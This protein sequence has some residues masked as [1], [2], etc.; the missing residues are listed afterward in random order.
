MGLGLLAAVVWAGRRGDERSAFILTVAAALALSPIVWL[1]YFALLLIVVALA[2]P[3]LGLIWF[4]PLAMVVTPGSGHPTPFE[5]GATLAIAALTIAL[6]LRTSASL[7]RSP[8][9]HV[10]DRSPVAAVSET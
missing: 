10:S 8:S 1:H 2:Q 6:A 3:T 7:S 9:P 4:V 5:T